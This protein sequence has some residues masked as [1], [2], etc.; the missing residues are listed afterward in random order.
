[1]PHSSFVCAGT[2]HENNF[3]F[4]IWVLFQVFIKVWKPRL[5]TSLLISGSL[6]EIALRAKLYISL[7]AAVDSI[8]PSRQSSSNIVDTFEASSGALKNNLKFLKFRLI[9]TKCTKV[10]WNFQ[11]QYR[12]HSLE[13]RVEFL[14]EDYFLGSFG[15]WWWYPHKRHGGI[16]LLGRPAWAHR[17]IHA[18]HIHC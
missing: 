6:F 15:T 7:K 5:R 2:T 9:K 16:K 10:P 13:F 17:Y 3:K 14:E 18:V 8:W 11:S 4:K 1:M 12:L